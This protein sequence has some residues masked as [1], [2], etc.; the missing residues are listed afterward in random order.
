MA[1][2]T[3][4]R[5]TPPGLWNMGC[6]RRPAPSATR[7]T[8]PWP[9]AP[10][11]RT[12]PSSSGGA[13]HSW[14]SMIWNWRRSGG[15]RGGTRSACTGPWATGH[16]RRWKPSIINIKRHKPPHYKDGTKIRPLH[17]FSCSAVDERVS[18]GCLKGG[19]KVNWVTG[20]KQMCS[21]WTTYARASVG[22]HSLVVRPKALSA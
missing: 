19:W 18:S 11:A 3:S 10:T 17:T 8:T 21:R 9:K 1:R 22:R 20:S 13:S 4:A 16:R 14:I 15:S 7:T 2:S 12:R 5:C 6:C